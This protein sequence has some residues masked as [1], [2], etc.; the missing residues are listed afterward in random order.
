MHSVK[1]NLM[2]TGG[3]FAIAIVMSYVGANPTWKTWAWWVSSYVLIN[4]VLYCVERLT[5]REP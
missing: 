2:L 5:R 3:G 1:K 4:V